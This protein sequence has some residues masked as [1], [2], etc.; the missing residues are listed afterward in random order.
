MLEW[1]TDSKINLKSAASQTSGEGLNHK[2]SEIRSVNLVGY[3]YPENE[4]G[5]I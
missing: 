3:I 5:K 2:F 4:K 1:I